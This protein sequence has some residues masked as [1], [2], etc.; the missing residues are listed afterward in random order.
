MTHQEIIAAAVE[1][2]CLNGWRDLD[3]IEWSVHPN[4]RMPGRYVLC[5][6]DRAHTDGAHVSVSDVLITRSFAQALFGEASTL[7][8]FGGMVGEL[9]AWQFH[10][11]PCRPRPRSNRSTALLQRRSTSSTRGPCRAGWSLPRSSSGAWFGGPRL[12]R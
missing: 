1:R 9:P 2:A 10:L 8:T 6:E 5:V 4:G 11:S 12:L 3:G 7:Y